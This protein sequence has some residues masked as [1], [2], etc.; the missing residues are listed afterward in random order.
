MKQTTTILVVRGRF[1]QKSPTG[2]STLSLW[3]SECCI[4]VWTRRA[5]KNKTRKQLNKYARH[6]V[7]HFLVKNV[8]ESTWHESVDTSRCFRDE[9]FLTLLK[10]P[11]NIK[12]HLILWASVNLVTHTMLFVLYKPWLFKVGLGEMVKMQIATLSWSLTRMLQKHAIW[13]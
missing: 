7:L 9:C 3:V 2:L 4:L 12:E 10:S 6:W 8:C 13:S 5:I 1:D 11:I